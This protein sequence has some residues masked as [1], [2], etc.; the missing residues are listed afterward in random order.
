[1]VHCDSDH[2][3]DAA[4]VEDFYSV[5]LETGEGPGIAAPEEDVDGGGDVEAA[6]DV[7]GDLAVS[8][9]FFA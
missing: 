2:S 8:K 3:T 5:N 4:A 7:K 6:A 9:K 1:M